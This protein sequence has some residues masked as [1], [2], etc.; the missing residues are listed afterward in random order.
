MQNRNVGLDF[1]RGLCMLYIVGFWHMFNYTEAFREYNNVFTHEFTA[2]VLGTF[3]F[4]SGYFIGAKEVALTKAS[5]L[6][7]YKDRLL[8]IY[9]LYLIAVVLFAIFHLANPSMSLRAGLLVSML[10]KPAPH[11]LW[12]ITMLIL[13]YAI[14]PW[15]IY[16]SQTFKTSHLALFYLLLIAGLVGCSHF[17][18]VIDI[19]PAMYF[20][21][22]AL[23]V[24]LANNNFA[25]FKGINKY[26]TL[27][28]LAISI[29]L[30][31]YE[32]SN[33]IVNT[34]LDIPIISL[35]SYLIFS[36]AQAF[37]VTSRK[38]RRSI[39]VLSYSSYCMYLFH[40]PIYTSL[41]DLYF[42]HAQHYQ[43]AYLVLFCLP[44]ILFLSFAIQKIY[45]LL[46]DAW[47][48][49]SGTPGGATLLV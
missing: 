6:K 3:V 20:P 30:A 43:L 46:L 35:G 24:Y 14:S 47:S 16:A 23:G 21:S 26:F 40:R 17:V 13:F 10:I 15:L 28:L 27:P 25:P 41:K 7:F 2:V 29:G 38:I 5:I 49:R 4:L 45:D 34:L 22:F 33:Y 36:A 37:R 31:F 39:A 11:T 19:R 12:F 8:R 18:T 32:T 42:P 44:C 1:L 48:N 9:P